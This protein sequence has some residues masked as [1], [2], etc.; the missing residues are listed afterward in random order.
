MKEPHHQYPVYFLDKYNKN[1]KKKWRKAIILL[2]WQWTTLS[3]HHETEE[4]KIVVLTCLPDGPNRDWKNPHV[5]SN[6]ISLEGEGEINF[7]QQ[8]CQS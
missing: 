7:K 8:F 6:W 3:V 2:F 4:V 5:S 1:E